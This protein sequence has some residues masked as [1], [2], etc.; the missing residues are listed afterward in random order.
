MLHGEEISP[1]MVLIE[2]DS[3]IL[4]GSLPTQAI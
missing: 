3:M 2:L 4:N 1:F